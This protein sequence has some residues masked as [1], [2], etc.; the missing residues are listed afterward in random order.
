MYTRQDVTGGSWYERYVKTAY[1][2]N[3]TG[4]VSDSKFGTGERITR[5]DMAVFAYRALAAAG[6]T[7]EKAVQAPEFTDTDEISDYAMEAITAMVE[8]GVLNGVGNG[9]FGPSQPA[10]RAQAAK[11]IYELIK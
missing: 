4:G 10:N 9:Q 3:I 2:L 7:L 11:M 5:Q 6:R 1:A 8:A